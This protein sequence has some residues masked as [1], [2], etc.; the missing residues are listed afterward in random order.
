MGISHPE[1]KQQGKHFRIFFCNMGFPSFHFP[2][3]LSTAQL[4]F[5]RELRKPVPGAYMVKGT[6]KFLSTSLSHLPN[7]LCQ[8]LHTIFATS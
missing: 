4:F 3:K 1:P 7:G 5:S 2:W 6:A 8:V